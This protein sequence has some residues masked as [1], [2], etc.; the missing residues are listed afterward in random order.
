MWVG[1]V[2]EDPFID[3]AAN[4]RDVGSIIQGHPALEVDPDPRCL[5]LKPGNTLRASLPGY[6]LGLIM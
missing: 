5:T 2:V 3:Q 6:I 4:L 1:E